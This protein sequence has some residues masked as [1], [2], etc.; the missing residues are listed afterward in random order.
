MPKRQ[1]AAKLQ[2]KGIFVSAKVIRGPDWDWG[3]QDGKFELFQYV[4]SEKLYIKYLSVHSYVQYIHV[5]IIF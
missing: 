1:G 3:N 5:C 4:L 2:M